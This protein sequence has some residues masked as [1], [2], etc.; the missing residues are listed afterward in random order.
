MRDT[1][2]GKLRH[3][4]PILGRNRLYVDRKEKQQNLAVRSHQ[5]KR[6]FICNLPEKK[7]NT[8]GFCD[9]RASCLRSITVLPSEHYSLAFGA[10][11]SCL[12]S[13]TVLP[14][15]HYSLALGA[16]QLVPFFLGFTLVVFPNHLLETEA[17]VQCAVSIDMYVFDSIHTSTNWDNFACMYTCICMH[18]CIHVYIHA[19]ELFTPEWHCAALHTCMY[20]CACMHT[21]MH[22]YTNELLAPETTWHKCIHTYMHAHKLL[23]L[24]Q[25][26]AVYRTSLP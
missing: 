5:E 21:Y 22:T 4:L 9:W 1:P 25:H 3:A 19:R 11:Q 6:G 24:G 23:T 15:E 16:L 12:R 17:C 10:L 8:T 26:S 20:A 18:I 7:R 13:I 2:K 14:S